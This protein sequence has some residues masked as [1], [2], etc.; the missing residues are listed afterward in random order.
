MQNIYLAFIAGLT[1]GGISCFAIQ[2][3]L[4]AS[5][6]GENNTRQRNV[7]Q[8]SLFLAAKLTAYSILGL[9]LG[10]IGS[11]FILS[12]KLQ[13]IIQ[14]LIGIFLLGTAARMLDLH[15]FFRYFAITPP[16]V[17]Y[18]IARKGSRLETSFAP[19]IAGALTILLP[20]GVT[21]AM[22][23]TAVASGTAFIGSMTMFAF[24]LGTIPSF[25]VLGVFATELL[26][27]K[28][29]AFIAAGIIAIIGILSLNSSLA[30][31]GS[32]HTLQNYWQVIKGDSG[33]SATTAGDIKLIDGVQEATI[34]VS[35]GG[36]RVDNNI[37]KVG[38]PARVRLVTN[39]TFSCARAFTIPS[40]GITKILKE[41]GTE[42]IEF[43]PKK[44]GTLNFSCTMGMYTG[45]FKI[46]K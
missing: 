34:T 21:Q 13:A 43:T 10:Y 45:S 27:Q 6:I 36:Y 44:I 33:K 41:T 2:S 15:P 16:K 5:S 1:T 22:M 39:N 24:I 26:K 4:L 12:S 37:L 14:L 32:E 19:L 42:I 31:I 30:L 23:L 46:V 38:V 25:F 35:N 3:G 11:F 9:I 20:C 18:K 29:V 28:S 7:Y 8:V 40:L 17:L